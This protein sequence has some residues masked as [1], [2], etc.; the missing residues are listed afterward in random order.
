MSATHTETMLLF[1]SQLII[2]PLINE[3]SSFHFQTVD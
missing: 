2:I 1:Y 3:A